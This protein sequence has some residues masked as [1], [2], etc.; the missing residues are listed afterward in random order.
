MLSQV[1]GLGFWM[2]AGATG[3]VA[4]SGLE[5]IDIS[6]AFVRRIGTSVAHDEESLCFQTRI[7]NSAI[8]EVCAPL[9]EKVGEG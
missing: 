7:A 8:A 4:I 9:E 1:P 3:R 2:I 5:S 6:N